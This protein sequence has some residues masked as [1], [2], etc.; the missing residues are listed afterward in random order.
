MLLLFTLT[1]VPLE[2]IIPVT[3]D[4]AAEEESV[5]IVL[6]FIFTI[7]EIFWHVNPITVP[8]V[9]VDVKFVIV[10]L[11][12]DNRSAEPVLLIFKPVIEF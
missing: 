9:P 7:G 1:I 3:L 2:I 6:E 12:I 8:P 4:E 5:L 10:L 11:E